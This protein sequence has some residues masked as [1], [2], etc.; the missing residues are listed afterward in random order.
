MP[1]KHSRLPRLSFHLPEDA[2]LVQALGYARGLYWL[3]YLLLER[4]QA[5]GIP[6]TDWTAIQETLAGWKMPMQQE[7]ME[8]L[9]ALISEHQL[10]KEVTTNHPL[11][12]CIAYDQGWVQGY[13]FGLYAHPRGL[14]KAL[15]A[16]QKPSVLLPVSYRRYFPIFLFAL[17]L[18]A[19]QP[20]CKT[21]DKQIE[22]TTQ[23]IKRLHEQY[24]KQS[25]T[26]N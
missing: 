12:F 17:E 3:P 1:T 7:G 2:L 22:Q 9:A 10:L 20:I 6:L 14:M 18:I 5:I 11:A 25:S 24:Q 21:G 26:D 8:A 23:V 4:S 15:S 19:H 16:I 13:R